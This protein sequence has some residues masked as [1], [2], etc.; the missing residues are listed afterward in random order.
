VKSGILLAL[1]SSGILA[2]P[3]GNDPL[4]T[5]ESI[6][7]SVASSPSGYFKTAPLDG[8]P[9]FVPDSSAYS[10]PILKPQGNYLMPI[11]SPGFGRNDLP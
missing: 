11:I 4:E 2:F 6:P 3:P 5:G 9:I 1:A 7:G 10:M 8:M